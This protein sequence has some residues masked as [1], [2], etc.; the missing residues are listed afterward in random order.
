MNS[1]TDVQI[2]SLENAGLKIEQSDKG[3]YLTDGVLSLMGDFSEM[4]GRL[5]QSNLEREILIKAVRIKGF[6]G[7]LRVLDA[8]AGLGEDS[9]LLAAVGFKVSMYEQDSI[10]AMLLADAMN[11][12]KDK[13]HLEKIIDNMTLYN[14]NSIE[15][16]KSLKEAPEVVYLDPMFPERSKSGLIKKKFQLLQKLESPCENEE[17]LFESANILHP[18]KIVI[19]RPLKGAYLA[20]VKPS[21][22][23]MG[24]AIRYDC[25]VMA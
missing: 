21:Y 3:L 6:T 1:L 11:R 23:I 24:K 4:E 25:H 8:T 20:G 10:I 16:M 7:E 18:K 15:A 17:E 9:L 2:K 12:A 22:S 14:E 13:E 5:K 19:K